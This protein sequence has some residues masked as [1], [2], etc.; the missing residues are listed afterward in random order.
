VPRRRQHLLLSFS[1]LFAAALL[2]VNISSNSNNSSN[3]APDSFLRS[4]SPRVWRR[5]TAR[6]PDR[7]HAPSCPRFVSPRSRANVDSSSQV[8]DD[9]GHLSAPFWPCRRS[10]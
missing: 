5:A 8:D 2:A 6:R 4:P 10:L 3:G 7:R 1:W 9:C